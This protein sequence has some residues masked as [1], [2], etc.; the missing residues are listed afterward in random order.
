[1]PLYIKDNTTAGLCCA[2]S[3]AR[4]AA[5]AAV[6]SFIELNGLHLV[7]IGQRE[8]DLAAQAYAAFGKGGI[9]PPST[10]AT[11]SPAHAPRRTMRSCCSRATTSRRSTSPPDDV[12]RKTPRTRGHSVTFGPAGSAIIEFHPMTSN[13]FEP[14]R[15]TSASVGRKSEAHSAI[16]LNLRGNV[17]AAETC[18]QP[19]TARGQPQF[20]PRQ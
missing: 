10:W 3:F 15:K 5:Q 11:A 7:A 6:Q 1:M 16:V 19:D 17:S 18:G 12:G 13:S 9:A 20:P 8:L 4:S 14:V 2:Y